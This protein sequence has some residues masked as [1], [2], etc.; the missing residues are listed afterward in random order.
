MPNKYIWGIPWHH[1][2]KP[3]PQ[4]KLKA[5]MHE[6]FTNKPSTVK[7]ASKAKERKQMVAIAYS[8]ARRGK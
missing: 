8:K 6:V 2:P 3:R 7:P 5:A 1:S 4:G